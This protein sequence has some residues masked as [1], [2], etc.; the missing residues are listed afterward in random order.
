M[1]RVTST[2]PEKRVLLP[3]VRAS[4]NDRVAGTLQKRGTLPL[5]LLSERLIAGES[6]SG[7]KA[8]W[9]PTSMNLIE[10][11]RAI[12]ETSAREI[13]KD[14]SLS[15]RKLASS[16]KDEAIGWTLR[17]RSYLAW[18]LPIGKNSRRCPV[19]IGRCANCLRT[20]VSLQ[21]RR[22][23]TIKRRASEGLRPGW[24]SWTPAT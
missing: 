24:M 20:S 8:S 5:N 3:W 2:L 17:G 11:A 18:C 21:Y 12:P 1:Q 23:P 13:V 9:L 4:R 6:K 10:D 15:A 14:G 16:V 19:V 7:A 22:R